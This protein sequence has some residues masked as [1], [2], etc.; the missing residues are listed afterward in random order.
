MSSWGR[1]KGLVKRKPKP[2]PPASTKHAQARSEKSGSPK[3]SRPYRIVLIDRTP[4]LV[5]VLEKCSS[6]PD[7]MQVFYCSSL[8]Q[9]KA[10]VG[11]GAVDLLVVQ[12]NMPDGDAMTLTQSLVSRRRHLQTLVISID[13]SI[14]EARQAVRLGAVDYITDFEDATY[15]RK[16]VR[17][18]L[19]RGTKSRQQVSRMNRL[20]RLCEKLDAARAEVSSQVDML[21]NDLIV[22]YQELAGQMQHVVQSTEYSAIIKDELDLEHVIRKTLEYLIDKLGPTNCALLLPSTADEFSVGGYVNYDCESVAA[23]MLLQNLADLLAPPIADS[24]QPIRVF[25][26]ESLIELMGDDIHGLENR[27]LIAVPCQHKDETLA[28]L[29]IFRDRAE[30]IGEELADLC[31]ATGPLLGEALAKVIRIHH[32]GMPDDDLFGLQDENDDSLPF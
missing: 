13:P 32:R 7:D 16:A 12:P 15:I 27:E 30:P 10:C 11:D 17:K 21:C 8:D 31:F 5:S 20:R 14:D 3:P 18:A 1:E 22:A 28:V 2:T 23:D 4:R 19:D 29:A 6:G 9:A 26:D 25:D 24:G